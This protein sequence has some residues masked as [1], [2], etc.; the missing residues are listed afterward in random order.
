MHRFI[1]RIVGAA[2]LS[3]LTYEE[4]EADATATAQALLVVALSSISAGL[5][6]LRLGDGRPGVF[7]FVSVLAFAGWAVWALLTLQIGAGLLREPETKADIGELLRTTGFASAPGLLRIFALIPG[8]TAAVFAITTVWMFLAM[9][10]AI[11]QALDYRSTARVVAVCAMGWLLAI[12]MVVVIGL[13]FG[14]A[15]S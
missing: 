13:L 4:V 1:S 3:A 9:I 12:V 11:R 10:V 5:G 14:P 7:I 15:L 2:R 8:T 6:V